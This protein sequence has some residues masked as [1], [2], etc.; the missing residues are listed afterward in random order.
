MFNK[1][2]WAK[3]SLLKFQQLDSII[4]DKSL[5]DLDKSFHAVCIVY[6]IHP[7]KL[8]EMKLKKVNKLVSKVA[9]MLNTNFTPP[10]CNR[11]GAYEIQYDLSKYTF[12]Q[13]VEL[14][15]Y[16]QS[17]PLQKSQFILATAASSDADGHQI[18]ENYFLDQ[19]FLKTIGSVAE[20]LKSFLS[21]LERWK[22]LF[23]INK[24][25]HEGNVQE[26]PF[27][28]RYGWFYAATQIAELERITYQDVFAMNII[29]AFNDLA[30]LKAKS[31][32][33]YEQYKKK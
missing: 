5:D 32:Y 20:I 29:H 8:D 18:R 11:I 3:I 21:F 6:D 16:L 2:K 23:G 30:Y 22:W 13:F 14:S 7:V 19:S 15:N 33:E 28:K 17:P 26:D 31:K 1:D 9:G 27:N 24:D 4:Q 12:G 25:Q 10:P